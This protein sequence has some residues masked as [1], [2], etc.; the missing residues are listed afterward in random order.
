MRAATFSGT[1]A[2]EAMHAAEGWCR[3]RCLTL[4]PTE[5]GH[6]RGILVGSTRAISRWINMSVSQR[7]GLDGVIRGQPRTG[8]IEVW[9][10]AGVAAMT[11]QD[12]L[13]AEAVLCTDGST[14]RRI[15][16]ALRGGGEEMGIV[17]LATAVW[18]SHENAPMWARTDARARE[19]AWAS[20]MRMAIN[21]LREAGIVH[22]RKQAC[23]RTVAICV[24]QECMVDGW[25][26]AE[27]HGN[28]CWRSDAPAAGR[29]DQKPGWRL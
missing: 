18:P 27:R 11:R 2:F 19:Y 25:S 13:K 15:V 3:E 12:R 14:E 22:R 7:S 1:K 5:A 6:P 20:Q 29:S 16:D 10:D 28:A 21:A 17:A 24:G 9:L 23:S 26:G 8:P 4:G